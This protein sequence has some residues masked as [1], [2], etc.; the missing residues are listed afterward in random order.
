MNSEFYKPKKTFLNL[1]LDKQKRIETV[2][3]QEFAT[4]GYRKASLNR[5]VNELGIAKGSLYQY[6]ANK[7]AIFLFIF[8]RFTRLVKETVG[9]PVGQG[10]CDDFWGIVRRV[11]LAGVTFI[12]RYPAYYQLYLKALFESDVPRREEIIR[13]VRLFSLEYFGSLVDECQRL[14]LLRQEV[15]SQMVVF[16]I[17]AVMDR[18]LQ[19]YARAYLDDG[20]ELTAKGRDEVTGD[21]DMMLDILRRGLANTPK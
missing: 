6:F 13:R 8:E 2:L 4:H 5:V 3:V 18:F 19:G 15:S 1:P 21:I 14:G 9:K 20:L 17:D 16:M 10:G 12:D 11:L 7:E